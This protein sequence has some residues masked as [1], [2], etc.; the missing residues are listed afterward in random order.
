MWIIWTHLCKPSSTMT[1]GVCGDDSTDFTA[2]QSGAAEKMNSV[3]RRRFSSHTFR[4]VDSDILWAICPRSSCLDD[5]VIS[6]CSE[7]WRCD[8]QM[9][10][11]L[12][13]DSMRIRKIYFY[14]V[15]C[16]FRY[17]SWSRRSWLHWEWLHWC[18]YLKEK[19]FQ[20]FFLP[21]AVMSFVSL[22]LHVTLSLWRKWN[23][24][25]S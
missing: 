25:H 17:W 4:P 2:D 7:G 18:K 13:I 9:N 5:N 21:N 14:Q 20:L 19:V 22:S 10:Q 23:K 11:T 16:A 24:N 8:D 3:L 15:L 12:A 6:L 1:V